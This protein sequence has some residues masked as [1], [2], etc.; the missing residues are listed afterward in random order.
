MSRMDGFASGIVSLE[1]ALLLAYKA[2]TA[3]VSVEITG[4]YALL[5]LADAVRHPS[6]RFTSAFP[7]LIF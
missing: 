4:T 3:T 2:D 6:C 1:Y 7:S 5:F